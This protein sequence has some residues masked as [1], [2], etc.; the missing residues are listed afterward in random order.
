MK[1]FTSAKHVDAMVFCFWTAVRHRTLPPS[2][3]KRLI[4]NI[5]IPNKRA[6]F[7]NIIFLKLKC[8]NLNNILNPNLIKYPKFKI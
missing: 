7:K 1:F 2:A 8:F 6:K 5:T 3:K 4:K